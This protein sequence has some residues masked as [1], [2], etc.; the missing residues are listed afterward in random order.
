MDITKEQNVINVQK[1]RKLLKQKPLDFENEKTLNAIMK[2][3][4]NRF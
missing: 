4:K 3:T 2:L 1:L